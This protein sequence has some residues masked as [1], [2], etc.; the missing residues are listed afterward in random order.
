MSR[1]LFNSSVWPGSWGASPKW[2]ESVSPHVRLRPP[3]HSLILTAEPHPLPLPAYSSAQHRSTPKLAAIGRA[4]GLI[5]H[6]AVMLGPSPA[7]AHHLD[8]RANERAVHS[9]SLLGAGREIEPKPSPCTRPSLRLPA[10]ALAPVRASHATSRG[11][12]EGPRLGDPCVKHW[13]RAPRA[14]VRRRSSR[15]TQDVRPADQPLG[16][17]ARNSSH[18]SHHSLGGAF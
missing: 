10:P 1:I 15:L 3:R 11:H 18:R 9:S 6:R 12:S 16:S 13:P 7:D 14:W 8:P 5:R 2:G 17:T 4:V